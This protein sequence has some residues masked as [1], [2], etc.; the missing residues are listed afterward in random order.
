MIIILVFLVV[1]ETTL[2]NG[3]CGYIKA[4]GRSTSAIVGRIAKTIQI[5]NRLANPALFTWSNI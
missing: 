1:T 4:I 3:T 2:I 5:S